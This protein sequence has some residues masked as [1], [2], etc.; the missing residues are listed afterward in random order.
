M[1]RLFS[2]FAL[3]AIA[4]CG[5]STGRGNPG[6]GGAMLMS[7]EV[8]PADATIAIDNGSGNAPIG[9][10]AIGHFSDGKTAPLDDAVFA[11]DDVGQRL[12]ALTGPQFNASGGAAGTGHVIATSQGKSGMTGVTVTVHKLTLGPG[13]P[14]DAPGKLPPTS[15][16]G[17]LSPVVV[18]P[19]DGALMPQS[20]AAPVPTSDRGY[21]LR[22]DPA[23]RACHKARAI[24]Q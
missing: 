22:T 6:G 16:P 14:S 21:N 9:Y 15:T 10:S 20:V 19:L 1:T 13:V 18:Y 12:G 24:S 23:H 3:A 4:G 11:L 2:F 5:P 17:A 7:I 8:Q